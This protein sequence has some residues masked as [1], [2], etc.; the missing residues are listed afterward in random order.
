MPKTTTHIVESLSTS[1]AKLIIFAISF[2][3]DANLAGHI[4]DCWGCCKSL[5]WSGTTNV[6]ASR[7]DQ[8]P[9]RSQCV[10]LGLQIPIGGSNRKI[11]PVSSGISPSDPARRKRAASCCCCC[12]NTHQSQLQ[13]PEIRH[14]GVAEEARRAAATRAQLGHEGSIGEQQPPAI[15]CHG[16]WLH[17]T[18][19]W[20]AD[21]PLLCRASTP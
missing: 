21:G 18:D 8:L 7:E 1:E 11:K 10:A 6:R 5:W 19:D 20:G 14:W 17:P 15:Q 4:R 12:P 16:W 13:L 2:Q 9:L 3:E